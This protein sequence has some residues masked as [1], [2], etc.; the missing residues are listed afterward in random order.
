MFYLIYVAHDLSR[1]ISIF[2]HPR[3]LFIRRETER[4]CIICGLAVGFLYH[5][6]QEETVEASRLLGPSS[7]M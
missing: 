2:L 4:E 1:H 3:V 5:G 6:L 7:N